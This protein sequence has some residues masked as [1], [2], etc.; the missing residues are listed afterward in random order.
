MIGPGLFFLPEATAKKSQ[1]RFPAFKGATMTDSQLNVLTKKA[2][3]NARRYYRVMDSAG[4]RLER[5]LDRLILRKT[6]PSGN[7]WDPMIAEF[8]TYKSS[9][10]GLEK[11]LAD[12]ISVSRI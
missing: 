8:N 10:G 12:A 11:A 5:R 3:R 2:L 9:L 6:R 7:E 1:E 4:E